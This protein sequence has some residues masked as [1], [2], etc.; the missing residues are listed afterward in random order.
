MSPRD[1]GRFARGRIKERC[2][3]AGGTARFLFPSATSAQVVAGPLTRTVKPDEWSDWPRGVKGAAGRKMRR[4]RLNRKTLSGL[5]A[6]LFGCVP[7]GLAAAQTLTVG[8]TSSTSD[9]PIYIA[10]KQG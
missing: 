3:R 10:D 1:V 6:C 7:P 5:L 8:A 4:T 2:L 9:A